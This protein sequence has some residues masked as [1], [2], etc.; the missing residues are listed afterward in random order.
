M[1][2]I[3][4]SICIA[5]LLLISFPISAQSVNDEIE[6]FT[7]VKELIKS[8]S[9]QAANE[10]DQLLK[11]K[12]KK[13]PGLLADIGQAYLEAGN[14]T[15]AKVYAD[16]ARKADSKSS[17]VY[18]LE[19]DIALA[20]KNVGKACQ[21]YEQAIYFNPECK[22]AYLK[23][24]NAYR[25]AS[26]ELAIEKLVELKKLDPSNIQAD[27]AMA[28]VYYN[29]NQFHKAVKAYSNFIDSPAATEN[30]ITKYA[31]ALFLDHKFEQSLDVVKKGLVRNPRNATFNRLAMYNNA[32]LK[33]YEEGLQ[34]ADRFFNASDKPDFAYLDYLY[35]AHLLNST[36]QYDAA[37]EQYQKAMSVDNKKDNLWREISEAYENK[38][39]YDQ[40]IESYKKYYDALPAG[41]QTADLQLEIGKLYYV[42]G[43]STDNPEITDEQK[44][45]ALKEADVI[46]A[47]IAN[48]V[49]DNYLGNFLR[50][51]VNSALDPETTEGLAKPYYE[52]VISM[53]S[54][55]NEAR[56]NSILVEC[57]SY[58]GY[59]YLVANKLPESKEYWQKILEIAPENPT[60]LKALE[61][62]K[63]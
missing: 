32:D 1:K 46:F 5:A 3:L 21:L 62:I 40:A 23:Y 38:G 27:Q 51:R 11:G 36:K 45:T 44:Q 29:N 49:P 28:D 50:A 16:L 18:I 60:A 59:Y 47:G 26:P 48:K 58:M 9:A 33:R 8:N 56:F 43:T 57:Y 30:D 6:G 41:K 52:A 20:E 22:E 15:E 7:K 17:S 4:S 31:F 13:N 54:S 53:L 34:A 42:K 37:I 25:N 35:Y 14:V 19:G 24:A 39:D 10:V 2:Q 63:G 55:K 12:N 61:G